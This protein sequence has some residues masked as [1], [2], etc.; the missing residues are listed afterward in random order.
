[1][2]KRYVALFLLMA[3]AASLYAM[4]PKPGLEYLFKDNYNSLSNRH[5]NTVIRPVR[6]AG[7]E[8]IVNNP[9]NGY[10]LLVA[11]TIHPIVVAI[12]Y[13]DQAYNYAVADFQNMLFGTWTSGSATDY[14]DEVSFGNLALAGTVSGWLTADNARAYYG[15]SSGDQRAAIL[16]KEAAQKADATIDY[17]QFDDNGDGYVDMF[18]VIHSGFGMEETGNGADIWSHSW[19]FTYAGIGAYTTDDPWPGHTGEYIKID[20]YTIDPERS[21]SSN[22]GTMVCIGVFCHEWGHALGL[23]DLYDT[24]YSGSGAG[25]WCTMAAGSW[26]GDLSS[27]WK[28]A[29]MCAWAKADMGWITPTVINENNTDTV[30]AA[31]TNPDAYQLWTDGTPGNE[32]FLIE[33]RQKTN[34]DATLFNSGLLIW[35]VDENIINATRASNKVNSGAVY[36][37]AVEQADGLNSLISGANN[38]DAGDPFPGTTGNDAFDST[39]TTPNSNSNAGENTHCGVNQIPAS[40]SAMVAN[41][42]MNGATA[43]IP[44]AD[45]SATPTS[46]TAPLSVTFTD[47]STG[48]PTEWSWDFGDGITSTSQNPVHAYSADGQYTVTLIASNVDGADTATK[49]NYITVGS[50]TLPVADFTGTPT[51]GDAP[52]N[53]TFTDQSTGA[54][55]GW[56]WSFGDGATST[57][58]NPVHSYTATGSF[59]V[60]LIAIN[61]NGS[62]TLTRT[63][64]I[65]VGTAPQPPVAA[66]TGTPTTGTA[67]LTVTFTDQSSN[68]P[69]SWSWDFGDGQTST[70]QSPSH[71][72]DTAGT[73]DVTLIVSNTAGADT[74]VQTGYITVTG[75]TTQPPTAAFTATPQGGYVPLSHRLEVTFTDQSTGTPAVSGWLWNFG[76][77]DTSVVQSPT[78]AYTA[79]GTFI[80]SLI[81]SNGTGAGTSDTAWDTLVVAV[82]PSQFFTSPVLASSSGERVVLEYGLPVKTNVRL[83]IYGVNGQLVRRVVSG[84]LPAGKYTAS[85]DLRDENGLRVKAGVY[86]LE[87]IAPDGRASSKIVITR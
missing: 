83:N 1:M 12:A 55:T 16:A 37:V 4:P 80:V 26:G 39:G 79:A 19:S 23:P 6:I 64:Y 72:Y 56:L 74:L 65:T 49:T 73:Y 15:Y 77:G 2:K 63:G 81:A 24:D 51:S 41:F 54:P 53:V 21:N 20:D 43:A 45:F 36:G 27:P 14:Y 44:V 70:T 52:L 33:N 47:L 5:F 59:D 31:E 46:G 13:T 87:L 76:D 18:T 68:A 40:S 30:Q 11:G 78:H 61:A 62:D 57:S 67:P 22:N 9:Q 84:E 48:T 29:H 69:T 66:F 25:A 28:P 50:G 58:Q 17:S 85:W 60:Q 35:H 42:Y 10:Q 34:F 75:G 3:L 71:V 8:G 86:F 7:K 32:Y 38:G 82:L